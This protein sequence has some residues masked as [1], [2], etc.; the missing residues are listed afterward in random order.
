VLLLLAASWFQRRYVDS[1]W[2]PG[3]R[4]LEAEPEIRAPADAP[5]AS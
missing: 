3:G 4:P 2:I 1:G 5:A